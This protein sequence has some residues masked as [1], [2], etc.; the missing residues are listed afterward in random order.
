[1]KRITSIIL[2]AVIAASLIGSLIIMRFYVTHH[3][4]QYCAEKYG[5]YVEVDNIS[6]QRIKVSILDK[7][8]SVNAS[9]D[10]I[11]FW[12]DLRSN[13]DN[14]V[15][16]Y[17]KKRYI[18]LLLADYTGNCIDILAIPYIEDR[19]SE[20]ELGKKDF[21]FF[22]EISFNDSAFT[23]NRFA[24]ETEQILKLLKDVGLANCDTLEA[25]AFIDDQQMH[26]RVSPLNSPDISSIIA[27]IRKFPTSSSG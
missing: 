15:S 10:D 22:L 20:L 13:N 7:S 24:T 23:V 2:F 5:D 1:M 19:P 12:I 27:C 17:T 8:V 3:A 4:K 11:E 21:Q 16:Q 6:F 14:F 25:F 18:D 26:V 9:Y